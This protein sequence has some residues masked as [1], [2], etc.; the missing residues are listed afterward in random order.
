MTDT[1][2]PTPGANALGD[3]TARLAAAAKRLR[4]RAAAVSSAVCGRVRA[5]VRLVQATRCFGLST[6]A[7]AIFATPLYWLR[8]FILVAAPVARRWAPTVGKATGLMVIVAT[9]RRLLG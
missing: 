3:I 1:I 9:G 6:V 7:R 8:R 2:D 5:V 4:I